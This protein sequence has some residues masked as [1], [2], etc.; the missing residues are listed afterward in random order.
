ML[1]AIGSLVM[2]A[3]IALLV[4]Q[5][6]S[7]KIH[8]ENQ[9]S[10]K[11]CNEKIRTIQNRCDELS[12]N[13]ESTFQSLSH[14]VEV[15]HNYV[16]E[17][18]NAQEERQDAL[19]SD[20]ETFRKELEEQKKKL[21]FYVGIDEAAETLSIDENAEE[22]EELLLKAQRQIS[23]HDGEKA[24]DE[25][26]EIQEEDSELITE[27]PLDN[28]QSFA[29]EYIESNKSNVFITGKAGTGK[30]FLLDVF[31]STTGKKHIVLAP[32]GIAA[33]NVKGATL[34]TT[35]GYHNLETLKVEDINSKTLKLKDEKQEVL[36]KVEAI[37]IDEISMVRADILDKIDRILRTVSGKDKPFGGK[38]M[39]LFGD[40]FQLP[41]V[42][43]K[44]E[45]D[46]LNKRYGGI[47]FFNSE[48]YKLGDF[49]FVE[50]THNH[51]QKGDE[52]FFEILNRI[53]IGQATDKDMEA[54]NTR[55]TPEQ[56]VY[57]RYINLFPKK[58]DANKVNQEQL[59]KLDTEEFVYTAQVLIDPKKELTT[60]LEKV[61]PVLSELKLKLGASVM[62][63]AND[64]ARRWVN[65][66]LGIVKSLSKDTIYVSFGK[67]KVYEIHKQEFDE[68]EIKYRNNELEYEIIYSVSQYPLIPAYAITIHKAQGQTYGNVACDVN[69]CFASGQA[70]VA[71][72]R[73]VSLEGLHLKSKVTAG[74]IM[75]NHDIVDFYQTQLKRNLLNDS[76][77]S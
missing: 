43:D 50:L 72:S 20:L 56:S 2:I 68:Y 28:E 63:V 57:D 21:D 27:N 15:L 55:Y 40:L 1:Y 8:L 62:M 5:K 51:R 70:Y 23:N 12:K 26:D 7:M 58:D 4:I 45:I 64:P 42:A 52:P 6:K 9:K 35:F 30:S 33:L 77:I 75:V 34:H 61:F 36:R 11:E 67:D 24:V 25:N 69:N 39:I 17:S 32:T 16:L 76:H 53:R 44:N 74:N 71:L 73:C 46:Y 60:K 65:G 14:E 38:Q 59:D 31:R 29:R 54:L 49:Q 19:I 3:I 22:R 66:S 41:P 37:I 48:A 10:I 47:Y 13:Q 18:M